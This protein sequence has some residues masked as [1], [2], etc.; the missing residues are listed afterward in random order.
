MIGVSKAGLDLD[1]VAQHRFALCV[2]ISRHAKGFGARGLKR[3]RKIEFLA[4]FD[5]SPVL[6]TDI[7]H[8]ERFSLLQFQR[9]LGFGCALDFELFPFLAPIEHVPGGLN[10][11]AAHVVWK[12][13][14]V[15]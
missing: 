7:D 10:P 12:G 4:R 8:H 13:A 15:S 14:A 5:D 11:D 2:S 1:H 6:M 3:P 9:R